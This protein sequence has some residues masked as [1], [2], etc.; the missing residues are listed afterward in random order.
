MIIGIASLKAG[1]G[2]ST[3]AVNLASQL[4]DID[5]S[6]AGRW[7]GKYRVVLV[8]ADANGSATS[9]RAGGRLP[10]SIEQ[11]LL[12]DTESEDE[13]NRRIRAIDVDYVVV[14]GPSEH[15]SITLA[16]MSVCDLLIVPCLD[17][18]LDFAE[19]PRT[20]DLLA[21]A[22]VARTTG[23]PACLLAPMRVPLSSTGT[24]FRN[25]LSIFGEPV[26]AVIHRR[27]AFRRASRAKGWIGEDAGALHAREE[28]KALASAVKN[29]K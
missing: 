19:T 5:S 10:V 23:G 25:A 17:S 11:I 28:M 8:D 1:C 24:K 12:Q 2:K 3:C 7:Q 16:I 21:I 9:Y 13:W 14:D 29:Q 22:R 6:S 26:A 20:M 15:P 27:E 4:A 18:A